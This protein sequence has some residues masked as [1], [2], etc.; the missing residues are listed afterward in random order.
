M[1]MQGAWAQSR[2]VPRQPT[3]PTP[4]TVLLPTKPLVV[5]PGKKPAVKLSSKPRADRAKTS[6]PDPKQTMAPA[7]TAAPAG[8]RPLD[9]ALRDPTPPKTG[10]P[11]S[12][13]PPT[14]TRHGGF[15]GRMFQVGHALNQGRRA[16]MKRLRSLLHPARGRSSAASGE[17]HENPFA[18]MQVGILLTPMRQ[19]NRALMRPM[20]PQ[21][22]Y[23]LRNAHLITEF[24]F[25]MLMTQGAGGG[26]MDATAPAQG[27]GQAQER[28]LPPPPNASQQQQDGP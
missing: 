6:Q 27:G 17:Y 9:A 28:Q 14:S 26:G 20:A 1:M 24:E 13:V 3:N 18:N 22:L 12:T 19:N 7:A 10:K 16:L 25:R 4:T 15:F 2:Q 8:K 5:K 21:T 11:A 23:Q